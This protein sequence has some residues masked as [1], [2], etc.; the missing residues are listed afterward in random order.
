LVEVTNGFSDQDTP[1]EML[2]KD[3]QFIFID[4]F[5][6]INEEKGFVYT[7]EYRKKFAKS[8]KIKWSKMAVWDY[9][10]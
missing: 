2:C 7:E 5:N 3:I 8:K 9:S 1:L 10:T 4:F 6:E